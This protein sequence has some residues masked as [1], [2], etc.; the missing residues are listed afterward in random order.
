MYKEIHAIPSYEQRNV[1]F[2]IP[3][4]LRLLPLPWPPRLA[5]AIT[6]HGQITNREPGTNLLMSSCHAE[7]PLRNSLQQSL[8]NI[9]G[10]CENIDRIHSNTS[11]PSTSS[12]SPS[13]SWTSP[14]DVLDHGADPL[15]GRSELTEG[16]W[17]IQ[18]NSCLGLN[19]F[20]RAREG[21]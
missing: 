19:Q 11:P 2:H 14:F 20:I 16:S 8:L 13:T 9:H 1:T 12:P 7:K 17:W 15:N 4:P 18:R 5:P 3:R 6:S 21:S 10:W